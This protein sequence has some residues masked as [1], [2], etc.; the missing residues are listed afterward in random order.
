MG[1]A[2]AAAA[3]EEEDDGGPKG[4]S[5]RDDDEVSFGRK[6]EELGCSEGKNC[7]D[8]IDWSSKLPP[9]LDVFRPD[10]VD[11]D[12][13]DEWIVDDIR[14]S[15]IDD[16]DT[17]E[18]DDGNE[19]FAVCWIFV[20]DASPLPWDW[21]FITEVEGEGMDESITTVMNILL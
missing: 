15:L 11:D 9:V 1:V 13:D 7:A 17:V 6:I 5:E 10:A 16:G 20:F 2:H 19:L 21:L 12:C 4:G 3:E 8:V 18:V 14:W